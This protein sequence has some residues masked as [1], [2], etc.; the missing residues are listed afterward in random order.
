MIAL[1]ITMSLFNSET[2]QAQIVDEIKECK[3]VKDD[4]G[5]IDNVV[6]INGKV[7][8]IFEKEKAKE[9]L[10]KIE[11]YSKLEEK[12]E[13]LASLNSE[14]KKIIEQKEI[15][16][17]LLTMSNNQNF[18]LASN[19]GVKELPFYKTPE[20]MFV[21]GFVL[22]TGGYYLYQLGDR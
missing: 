8:F 12:I 7:Y 11:N 5:I 18:K 4:K 20:F 13:D 2:I 9:I 10:V 3:P 16:I 15:Q 6:K 17:S 19:C 21:S 14:R 22:S 1:G